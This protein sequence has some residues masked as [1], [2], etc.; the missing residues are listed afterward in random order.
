MSDHPTC[1]YRKNATDLG[2]KWHNCKHS[3]KYLVHESPTGSP[4]PHIRPRVSQ[5]ARSHCR[6]SRTPQCRRS[7]TACRDCGGACTPIA[8][9]RVRRPHRSCTLTKN[10]NQPDAPVVFQTL[11]GANQTAGH[12]S[13]RVRRQT[14]NR[15]NHIEFRR[16][17]VVDRCLCVLCPT[18]FRIE[19]IWWLH[20]E[21]VLTLSIAGYRT[22]QVNTWHIKD[23]TQRRRV[24]RKS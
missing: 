10:A 8:A 13:P 15:N 22:L 11:N 23:T 2:G 5:S 14:H 17:S 18:L 7:S 6:P 12:S 24:D 3:T 20:P 16:L 9:L 1:W 4:G 21:V 19:L